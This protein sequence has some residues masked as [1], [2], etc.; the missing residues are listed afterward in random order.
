MGAIQFIETLD[1]TTLTISDEDFEKNV[2][3]AVSA[4][5]ERHREVQESP[6]TSQPMFSE[7][8]SLSGPEVT[9]RNSTDAE[10]SSP[11]RRDGN[12][13]SVGDS[14]EEN[15][16]V[17]GLLRSIQRPLSTIGR[18]FSDDSAPQ[19]PSHPAA[20]PQPGSTP[21][22]SPAVFQTPRN[23]GEGRRSADLPLDGTN[24]QRTERPERPDRPDRNKLNAE[25]AAARQA[26]AE[27]A[28]ARR[29]Q[30]AEHKDVVE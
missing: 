18:I 17:A 13:S 24:Q 2:E 3:A 25:E 10:Y 15:A 20:T 21:R 7:K 14:L 30:R 9:P 4:I 22:L 28:E 23:S 5:A 29:I 19:R 26:N 11:R 1:R 8:S 6:V 16:A 27:A 12:P